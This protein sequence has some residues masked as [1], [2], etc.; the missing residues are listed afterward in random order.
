M[1]GGHALVARKA[2]FFVES[3]AIALGAAI[4]SDGAQNI[5]T[6][7][8]QRLRVGDVWLATRDAPAD[9]LPLPAENL[10]LRAD[11]A[12]VWHDG[13]AAIWHIVRFNLFN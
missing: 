3:G 13:V 10:T 12:W 1:D 11:V 8:E 6:A 7:V 4:A 5:A 2:W 9:P